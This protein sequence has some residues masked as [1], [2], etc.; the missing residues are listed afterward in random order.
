MGPSSKGLEVK[1]EEV[2]SPKD[3]GG[4]GGWNLL[5]FLVV[6]SSS[7]IVW[8]CQLQAM[9]RSFVLFLGNCNQEKDMELRCQGES[10]NPWLNLGLRGRS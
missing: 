1:A 8:G 6:F 9:R 5:A 2:V 3:L 10:V 7:L 4:G